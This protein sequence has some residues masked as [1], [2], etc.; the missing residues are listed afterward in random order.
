MLHVEMTSPLLLPQVSDLHRLILSESGYLLVLFFLKH[1]PMMCLETP[2]VSAI[3][4]VRNN[5]E[6]E[7]TVRGKFNQG[8]GPGKKIEVF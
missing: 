7:H 4:K 3:A 8:D 1:S 6:H 2:M 5:G